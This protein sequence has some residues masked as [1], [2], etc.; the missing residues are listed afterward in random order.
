MMRLKVGLTI[1][2]VFFFTFFLHA[3]NFSKS[4]IASWKAQAQRVNIVRDNWGVPH[5]YTKTDADAVFGMMYVQSESYFYK[6]ESAIIGKLGREAEVSGKSALYKDL[7]SRMFIDTLQAKKLL[8]QAT[9]YMQNLCKAYAAGMNYFIYT[10]PALKPTLITRFQPWMPLMNNIPSMAGFSLS[11]SE[12]KN[13]YPLSGLKEIVFTPSNFKEDASERAGSNGWAIASKLTSAH[14]P[15]I[16][17]NPHS[18]FYNRIEVQLVSDEG[19]NVYGAPFLGEFH[20][21]QGFNAFCGWMHT[22]TESDS[23]DLYVEKTS[24]LDNGTY[25]YEYDNNWKSVDS[26]E[27]ILHFTNNGTLN[28]AKFTVY[29]THHG[30]VVAKRN[31]QWLS[32]KSINANN[33]LLSVHWNITKSKTYQ[34]FTGWLNKRVMTG[35]NTIYADKAGNIAYWHG[36]FVPIRDTG[37][38]WSRPVPGNISA[39]EWKGTHALNGIPNY[40]NPTNGWVQNSNST[41][42]YG[43]GQFDSVMFK[44]PSY[45]FP[46]GHT[47]RAMNAIEQLKNGKDLSVDQVINMA[48]SPFLMTAKRFIP[49]LIASYEKN[50]SDSVA[51][52]LLEPISLLKQWD[53]M[54]DTNSVATALAVLW[55]EKLVPYN[56]EKLKQPITYEE[57]YSVTNGSGLSL[58]DISSELQLK[59]LAKVVSDLKKDWG[60]WQIPWGQINRYQRSSNEPSD[61]VFS[62]AVT[63]APGFMGSLNA[64]VSKKAKDT[65][66]RYGI[67]GNTFVAAVTFGKRISG[68]TILTG[69]SSSNP[70]SAHYTDQSNGYINAKYKT[71][72]FYKEDVMKSKQSMYHPGEEILIIN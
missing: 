41:P 55:V 68:K 62:L 70:A 3:Q 47:P 17:I 4:E 11:E 34:E 18:E 8:T 26:S 19:L 1:L 39:T 59:L 66:S 44:K 24:L 36:N 51:Q 9:P 33:A 71:L 7:W 35:T 63:A 69:G 61:S 37:Y 22:V 42:L 13:M 57:G 54:A 53:F 6:I 23:R 2:A 20:I 60:K 45:M 25:K 58:N 38:D 16:L 12:V 64:Y 52:L 14:S 10:H 43:I 15:M 50:T 48:N 21:W 67:S 30:P 31:N 5:I 72:L 49:T 32:A 27:I 40:I 28:T 56:L 65:K 46:D 29:K